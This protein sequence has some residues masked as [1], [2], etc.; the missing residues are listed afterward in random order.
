MRFVRDS[1][2]WSGRKANDFMFIY[3]RVI[4]RWVVRY[5]LLTCSARTSLIRIT[6][7]TTQIMQY[8]LYTSDETPNREKNNFMVMQCTK[9]W[10]LSRTFVARRAPTKRF[11]FR[12]SCSNATH[13]S[14]LI[15]TR[16][17]V[18]RGAIETK[19]FR[20]LIIN[21]TEETLGF[22]GIVHLLFWTTAH[23]FVSRFEFVVTP[24]IIHLF[25]TLLRML[26]LLHRHLNEF[27]DFGIF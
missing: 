22:L 6:N 18:V 13:S 3:T 2:V 15:M 9:N 1:Y 12:Q 23:S 5:F 24:G 16:S 17:M 11:K 10:F 14:A 27:S 7:G 25:K 26:M 21:V 8:I 19:S 20:T 4:T